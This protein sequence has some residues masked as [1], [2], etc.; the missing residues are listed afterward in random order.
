[1][2]KKPW[3]EKP[4]SA[5][6]EYVPPPNRPQNE[7]TNVGGEINTWF[8][9]GKAYE[10]HPLYL[11]D[12]LTVP[13]MTVRYCPPDV[14]EKLENEGLLPKEEPK[15]AEESKSESPAEEKPEAKKSKADSKKE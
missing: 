10:V 14:R 7:G 5:F 8:D 11:R 2:A 12:L 13:G 15:K 6:V 3:E 4:E 9:L 1:M